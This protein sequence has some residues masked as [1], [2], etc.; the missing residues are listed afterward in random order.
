MGEKKGARQRR[1]DPFE[2]WVVGPSVYDQTAKDWEEGEKQ[3]PVLRQSLFLSLLRMELPRSHRQL[4]LFQ[5]RDASD[6]FNARPT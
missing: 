6:C 5:L 1:A 2:D 3:P 4:C